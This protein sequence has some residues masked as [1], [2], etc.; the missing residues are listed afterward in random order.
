MKTKMRINIYGVLGSII[1][2]FVIMPLL[3]PYVNLTPIEMLQRGIMGLFFTIIVG[4]FF[5]TLDDY[6][7][8]KLEHGKIMRE[9]YKLKK[10][11]KETE[12]LKRR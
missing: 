10:E 5:G 12:K 3:P 1:G 4:L 8:A 9:Y 2:W 6:F 7:E 11:I